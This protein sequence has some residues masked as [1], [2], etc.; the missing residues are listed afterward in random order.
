MPLSM[1]FAPLQSKTEF[2]DPGGNWGMWATPGRLGL[3]VYE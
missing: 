2:S 3:S 1:G